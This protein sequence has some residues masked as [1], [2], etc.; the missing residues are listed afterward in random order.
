MEWNAARMKFP[1]LS[2]VMPGAEAK[3]N[4]NKTSAQSLLAGQSFG[5]QTSTGV[6]AGRPQT[7]SVAEDDGRYPVALPP[8]SA[9]ML[10]LYPRP[11]GHQ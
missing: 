6:L 11:A 5:P 4:E 7:A 3:T 9:A 8:A 10:V 2:G 1:V